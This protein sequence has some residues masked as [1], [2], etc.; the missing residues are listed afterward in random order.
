M[1]AMGTKTSK[2][3]KY[4]TFDT[5]SGAGPGGKKAGK[6]AGKAG[7]HGKRGPGGMGYGGLSATRMI[8]QPLFK[9]SV[10]SVVAG[11]AGVALVIA[12]LRRRRGTGQPE[13]TPLLEG[14][15]TAMLE[16]AVI[17]STD[18]TAAK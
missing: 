9:A 13:T 17:G 11:V 6:K 3:G 12:A 18:F 14:S 7:K 15:P 10:A 16:Y 4:L 8:D 1:E 5:G 2:C